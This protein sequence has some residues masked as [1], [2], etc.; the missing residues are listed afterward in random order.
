MKKGREKSSLVYRQYFRE[1]SITQNN[2]YTRTNRIES[3]RIN[4]R[5]VHE[6]K[7][8]EKEEQ[9]RYELMQV[10]QKRSRNQKK[11]EKKSTRLYMSKH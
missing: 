9:N 8:K 3:N 6:L 5:H 4:D 1:T 2:V 11:D 7:P 10:A